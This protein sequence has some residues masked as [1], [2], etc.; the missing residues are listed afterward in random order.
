M[1]NGAL[2]AQIKNYICSKQLYMCGSPGLVVLRLII[3][4]SWVR[5]Q[6]KTNGY[7]HINVWENCIFEKV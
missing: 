3:K 1:K 4:R 6:P 2:M 7:F 5:L